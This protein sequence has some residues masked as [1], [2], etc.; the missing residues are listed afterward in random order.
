MS[1]ERSNKDFEPIELGDRVRD[2][3]TGFEGIANA[4]TTWMNGCIRIAIQPEKLDK[5]GKVPDDRYFDQGQLRVVK[6][7]VHAPVTLTVSEIA[8]RVE[9]RRSNGGPERE[10]GNFRQP[11][12]TKG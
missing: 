11:Q 7:R 3:V 6:K 5:D 12:S 2:P 1:N 10:G 4:V 9:T 8:P